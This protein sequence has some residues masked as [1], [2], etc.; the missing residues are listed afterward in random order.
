MAEKASCSIEASYL[1][2]MRLLSSPLGRS[3]R[4]WEVELEGSRFAAMTV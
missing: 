4:A 3:E 1:T 2:R